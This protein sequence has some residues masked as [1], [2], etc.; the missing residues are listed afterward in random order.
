MFI[1][2]SYDI[3]DNKRRNKVLDKLKNY[4]NHVQY[5]VFECDI[6]EAQISQLQN[7]I[8]VIINPRKDS[9]LYYYMCRACMGK[10]EVQGR[11][12]TAYNEF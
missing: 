9:V 3:T 1:V 2:I 6:T 11:D 4:G 7:R 8:A 10:C 12:K 5:S